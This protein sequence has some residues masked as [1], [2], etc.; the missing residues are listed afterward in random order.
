MSSTST[1]IPASGTE[2]GGRW[3]LRSIAGN[4]LLVVGLCIV[5]AWVALALAAPRIAPYSPLEQNLDDR[6]QAP[7]RD[8][9][10]G[11]DQ[12]G[13]DIFSRV[14]YGGRI[15]L[16]AGF[17]VI[18][19]SSVIGLLIGAVGGYLG[20]LWDEAIMRFTE[21]FQAFPTIILALAI[22]AA[23]GPAIEN[24][25]LAL[26]VVWWPRFARLMR[27]M[28]LAVKE[29]DYVDA[30]RSIGAGHS[31]LLLRVIIPNTL[32]T[33][34]A[35][36]MLDMGGAILMFAGLGFL[37]LGPS[38]ASPEWGRMVAVGIDFF[39]QW[40]MWLFPG[41]AIALLVAALNFLGDA[42]RDLV[43]PLEL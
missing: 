19:F 29:Q 31:Y 6:M 41:A 21:L 20:G 10:F 27:G 2:R 34:V 32:N 9:L 35:L 5:V 28:V 12:L 25:I 42:W 16:P 24:A 22:T 8:H 43:D 3:R 33:L 26:I 13:R 11:T 23:L 30:T 4:P 39:D 1:S 18:V 38:A 15:T 36:A 7:S 37:G 14:L 40:W 17:L